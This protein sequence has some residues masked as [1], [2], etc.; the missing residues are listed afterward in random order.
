MGLIHSWYA[1]ASGNWTI[2]S[3][4]KM[5]SQMS[6]F[7]DIDSVQSA[8][9]QQPAA[10]IS[11]TELQESDSEFLEWV[12]SGPG[13]AHI[14]GELKSMRSRAAALMISQVSLAGL[15]VQA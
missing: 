8:S 13:R 1:S 5:N 11:Y 6:G 14:G 3:P 10:C 4:S 15:R 9:Q 7:E 12:E 2:A